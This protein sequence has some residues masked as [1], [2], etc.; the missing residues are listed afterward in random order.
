MRLTV[1]WKEMFP[2][3]HSQT[4]RNL[5]FTLDFSINDFRSSQLG[6][7]TKTGSSWIILSIVFV[8][9]TKRTGSFLC[10]DLAVNKSGTACMS[11]DRD[12]QEPVST[13]WDKI[14]CCTWP[15]NSHYNVWSK[16]Q[17]KNYVNGTQ[18]WKSEEVK[19]PGK[20]HH[21]SLLQRGSRGKL[22]LAH[23]IMC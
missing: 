7:K 6:I 21:K 13:E 18:G 4:P 10:P 19:D 1:L 12:P 11:Q 5:L 20:L 15:L 3:G 22:H 17:S 14:S 9:K 8:R 23:L 16:R 2:Q